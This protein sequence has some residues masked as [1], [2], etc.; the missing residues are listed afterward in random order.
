MKPTKVEDVMTRAVVSVREDTPFKDLVRVMHE[1][2][3]SGVPV[4]DAADRVVGIVTEADL[5]WAEGET[6]QRRPRSAF[7][8]WFIHPARLAEIDKHAGDLRAG[9]VMT[10][11]VVTVASETH[12]HDAIRTLREAGVK[13]L[14]VVDAERRILGIVGRRDLLQQFLRTDEYI[15]DEVTEEVI[16]RT[17]WM[18]P[19][20]IDVDVQRGL[21]TLHGRVERRSEKAI[22]AALV[23]R[24]DGVVGLREELTYDTDDRKLGLP[25]A[26]SELG[27]GENWVRAC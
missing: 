3:V 11:D 27:W 20:T 4:V 25:E 24:V 16:H 6:R 9:D 17:M 7:L 22:M 19:A 13:R 26:R 8:E 15:H 14:P 5:L 18:D 12:V 2:C 23:R 1:N 21:V 10:K